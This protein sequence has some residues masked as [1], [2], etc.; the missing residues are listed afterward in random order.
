MRTGIKSLKQ[1]WLDRKTCFF[2]NAC[3]RCV[4][5]PVKYVRWSVLRKSLT[6]GSR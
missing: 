5:N 4:K 1:G 2:M 3:Q 6:A